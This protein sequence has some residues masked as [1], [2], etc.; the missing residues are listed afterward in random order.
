MIFMN[1]D[2]KIIQSCIFHTRLYFTDH[3][4]NQSHN[5]WGTHRTDCL[6]KTY[7]TYWKQNVLTSSI[8]WSTYSYSS[9]P[10]AGGGVPGGSAGTSGS[11]SGSGVL[12]F[13]PFLPDS[14]SKWKKVNN[15]YSLLGNHKWL[16]ELTLPLDIRPAAGWQTECSHWS[17]EKLA[18]GQPLC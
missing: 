2:M 14:E 4:I 8:G 13:L 12:D 7:T 9:V 6:Y 10:G 17:S 11:G 1:N 18:V 16:A 3:A 5:V 15:W